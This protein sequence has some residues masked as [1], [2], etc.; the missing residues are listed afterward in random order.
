MDILSAMLLHR[1][2]MRMEEME[3]VGK[4]VQFHHMKFQKKDAKIGITI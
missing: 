3:R 1:A 4:I 2:L